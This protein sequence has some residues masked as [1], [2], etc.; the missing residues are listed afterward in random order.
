LRELQAVLPL[1]AMAKSILPIW[2]TNAT[3]ANRERIRWLPCGKLESAP[4]RVKTRKIAAAAQRML[5][6]SSDT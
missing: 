4:D 5:V 1:E 3:S 2:I 6:A